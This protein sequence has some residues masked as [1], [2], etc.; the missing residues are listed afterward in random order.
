MAYD[1]T[2]IRDALRTALIDTNTPLFWTD[3][4]LDQCLDA[5][6]AEHS[7]WFPC[8]VAARY[9][10]AVGAERVH[11]LPTDPSLAEDV[12]VPSGTIDCDVIRITRVQLLVAGAWQE[13]PQDRQTPGGPALSGSS[14]QTN[15]WRARGAWLYIRPAI[16]AGQAGAYVL[17]V[18]YLQTWN[19]PSGSGLVIE[20][21]APA[22]HRPLLGLLAARNAY[23]LLG[24]WQAR[25]Q[26]AGAD[27]A[28]WGLT[29]GT[30]DVHIDV[31]KVLVSLEGQ[32]AALREAL[33]RVWPTMGEYINAALSE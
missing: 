18:E 13:W 3:V 15:G 12:P 28:T 1:R 26:E 16:A 4:Q 20:W 24:A 9:S 30:V 29:S 32:I 6:V 2:A 17:R 23:Q 14:R 5:A 33:A 22:A 8:A 19:R 7:G 31:N 10:L 27:P 21:N 25:V 11:I